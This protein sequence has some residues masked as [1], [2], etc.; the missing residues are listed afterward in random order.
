MA[1][2]AEQHRLAALAAEERA[3]RAAVDAEAAFA[4][5]CTAPIVCMGPLDTV[6][7][8]LSYSAPH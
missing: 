3:K 6:L 7:C 8:F 4:Q 1:F 2:A 5:V